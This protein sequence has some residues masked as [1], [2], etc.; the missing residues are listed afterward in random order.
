MRTA[1]RMV[2]T[3]FVSIVLVGCGNGGTSTATRDSGG[4][5]PGPDSATSCT[6]PNIVAIKAISVGYEHTCALTTA[7]G[8][9]CW[10]RNQ[11]GELGDGTTTN[12]LVPP[13][14]DVLTGVRAVSAGGAHTCALME[15]GGVRC[16]GLG[17]YIGQTGAGDICV[18]CSPSP[19][20]TDLL[21]GVRALS[22]GGG[23]VCALMEAGGV[24]CWGTNAHGQLGDGT[25]KDLMIYALPDR[26]VL[27]GVQEVVAGDQ[28]T[29]AIMT[30]G[31]LRC[32]GRNLEGQLGN[33]TT[34]NLQAPPTTDVL[35]DVKTVA[36]AWKNTCAVTT[37]GGVRC[38]G[39]NQNGQLGDGTTT[40]RLV[41]PNADVLTDVQ[42]VSPEN[43][44]GGLGS[45]CVLTASGGVRCWGDSPGDVTVPDRAIPPSTNILTGVQAIGSGN[46]HFCAMTTTGGIRCWGSNRSGCFGNGQ[47]FGGSSSPVPTQGFCQ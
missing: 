10:G 3:G 2:T 12:R 8:V 34:T 13:S 25:T 45:T 4:G 22:A 40:S 30:T 20:Q 1:P 6:G 46:A 39:D 42:S 38:W 9:R 15:S 44:G 33:G 31:G 14:D 32:W 37:A 24:R 21:R 29:C 41:P 28:H 43:D 19:P 27:T 5:G 7:G 36:L 18:S 47:E 17:V 35:S 11:N 23:H 26:D 16:W